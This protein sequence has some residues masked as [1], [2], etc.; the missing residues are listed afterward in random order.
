MKK[1]WLLCYEWRRL[2]HPEWHVENEA[3]Y[4]DVVSWVLEH[5]S[6]EHEE[7]RLIGAISI[8]A[9]QFKRL[10]GEI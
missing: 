4:G 5:H 3:F 2:G 1:H 6:T 9:Q 8:T 7:H 10:D